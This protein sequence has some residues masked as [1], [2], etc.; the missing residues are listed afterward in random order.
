MKDFCV[1]CG[2][3]TTY[4]I[5]T[6]ITGR[7]YFVEGA[8]QLCEECWMKLWPASYERPIITS[9]KTGDNKMRVS[10]DELIKITY[11]SLMGDKPDDSKLPD[12]K[13]F[14]Y[15]DATD[16]HMGSCHLFALALH[17]Q[18]DYEIWMI[19]EPC[20][21]YFCRK[22]RLF[23]DAGGYDERLYHPISGQD[24]TSAEMHRVDNIQLSDRFDQEGID[25][26]RAVVD[27]KKSWYCV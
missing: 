4:D 7:L 25:F 8:G 22:G 5:N 23:I 10:D 18:F 27:L 24:I 3:E 15:D 21:H 2:K 12:D 20:L 13:K 14:P 9:E 19:T 16:F 26:A 17:E 6:P 11:E 1:R